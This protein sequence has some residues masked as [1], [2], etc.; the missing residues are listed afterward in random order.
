MLHN[1]ILSDLGV[2]YLVY[3]HLAAKFVRMCLK[4]EFLVEANARNRSS[5][6]IHQYENNK[7]G[8]LVTTLVIGRNVE[9]PQ[10]ADLDGAIMESYEN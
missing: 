3:S 10:V 5:I 1:K 6:L 9:V 2:N 7:K 8:E 4:K